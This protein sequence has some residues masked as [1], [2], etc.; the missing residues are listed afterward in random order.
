MVLRTGKIAVSCKFESKFLYIDRILNNFNKN[1]LLIILLAFLFFIFTDA[2]LG[3]Q[4]NK[5]GP[6]NAYF[7]DNITYNYALT[8]NDRRRF[9][10]HCHSRQSIGQHHALEIYPLGSSGVKLVNHVINESNMPRLVNT[11]YATGNKA[12]GGTV[13]SA[14]SSWAVNLGFTGTFRL[15]EAPIRSSILFRISHWTEY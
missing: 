9:D 6:S 11:A 4:L 8:N 15:K 5:T 1:L 7:G 13:T 14:T 3:L 12:G 2:A 10:R